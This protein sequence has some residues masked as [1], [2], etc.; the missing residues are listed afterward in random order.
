LGKEQSVEKR[1]P[2]RSRVVA[3]RG[4]QKNKKEGEKASLALFR[5][6]STQQGGWFQEKKGKGGPQ[7][8]YQGGKYFAKNLGK[9]RSGEWLKDGPREERKGV[10]KG[11]EQ[12]KRSFVGT[13]IAAGEYICKN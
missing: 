12:K 2:A 1:I 10:G 7:C 13:P 5:T 6:K 11:K 4:A 3:G 9:K 8:E